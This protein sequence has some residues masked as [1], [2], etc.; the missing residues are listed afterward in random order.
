MTSPSPILPY[1]LFV[2]SID[3]TPVNK[4]GIDMRAHRLIRCCPNTTE[5]TLGHP[6]T[7]KS[8]TIREIAR[9][10]KR[11]HTLSMGGIESF[12][13]MLECDFAGLKQLQHVTL[14]TTPLLSASFMT[15]PS[16][17]K[18]IRLIQMDAV[19]PSELLVFCQAH[20]QLQSLAIVNCKAMVG[21]IG[22]VLAKL[23]TLHDSSACLELQE[24]ELVGHQISDE[25]LSALFNRVPKG[26][27]LK[28]L[29][30]YDTSVTK[31]LK[32]FHSQQCML[33]IENMILSN[34]R[35]LL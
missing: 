3:L 26:T 23:I 9:Y 13:F 33:K 14:K 32:A 27:R 21:N 5:M 6:T 20:T 16:R 22:E 12:P 8:E 35:Y 24:I 2:R 29:K 25:N 7:L 15:L 30:L 17:L 10:N 11:L 19:T 1:G 4:Y 31:S 18:S 28:S 34:N